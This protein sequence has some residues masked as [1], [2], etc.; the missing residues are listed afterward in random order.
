[1]SKTSTRHLFRQRSPLVLA[2]VCGVTGLVLLVSL[3]WEWAENPQPLFASWVLFGLALVW[4]F[5]VRPAVLLDDAGV[6]IRNVIRD[7]YIPW[8]QV[9]DVECRWSLKVLVGDR[10]F[11]SWAISS[12]VERPKGASGG[13][14]ATRSGHLDTYARADAPSTTTATKV[15]AM[16]VA[17]SI[18]QAREAYA[19][20]VAQGALAA[21][22]NG[23][24]RV[25]WVPLVL[26][27][28]AVSVLAI[29]ALS[30]V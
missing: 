12:Q 21:A 17:R 13:M 5:F 3:A 20:A 19:E 2:A 8:A 7:V 23:Q 15:T 25:T 14:F 1:M 30:L 4:S 11:T 22:P 16:M 9:T 29:A 26:A 27:V 18:E 10:A 24:V 28:L 6:T